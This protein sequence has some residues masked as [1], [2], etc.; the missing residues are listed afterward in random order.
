MQVGD[1]RKKIE[2]LTLFESIVDKL[3]NET[4]L[5]SELSFQIYRYVFD[6]L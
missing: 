3:L 4:N 5:L 1:G 2:C 6:G